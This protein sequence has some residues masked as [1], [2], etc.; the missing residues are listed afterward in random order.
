M[1]KGTYTMSCEV[2]FEFIHFPRVIGNN[3]VYCQHMCDNENACNILAFTQQDLL[4]GLRMVARAMWSSEARYVSWV[5]L[6]FTVHGQLITNMFITWNMG[7]LCMNLTLNWYDAHS[8]PVSTSAMTSQSQSNQ[9]YGLVLCFVMPM[10][11]TM[12]VWHNYMKV[13]Q[14]SIAHNP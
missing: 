12:D 2:A 13:N 4:N 6:I 1:C 5:P 9:I 11:Y 3:N 7:I 10:R 8:E 14:I